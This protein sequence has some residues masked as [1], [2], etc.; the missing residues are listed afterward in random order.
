MSFK[1]VICF[2][3][4]AAALSLPCC[5]SPPVSCGSG[6]GKLINLAGSHCMR[7]NNASPSQS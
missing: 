4:A 5:K 1:E 2:H 6:G 3:P 7:R